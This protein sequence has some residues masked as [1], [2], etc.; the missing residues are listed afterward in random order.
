MRRANSVPDARLGPLRVELAEK[1]TLQE[2]QRLRERDERR[3]IC[4]SLS[5]RG[6][7]RIRQI[8]PRVDLV[9]LTSS[10]WSKITGRAKKEQPHANVGS[11][12]ITICIRKRPIS[13]RKSR[14]RIMIV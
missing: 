5:K 3:K 9:T 6:P 11:N 13:S 1:N 10:I 4:R 2:I 7:T 12:K 14:S 8:A